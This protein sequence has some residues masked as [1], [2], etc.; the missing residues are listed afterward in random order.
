MKNLYT[1]VS[2]QRGSQLRDIARNA[3]TATNL[4]QKWK[5]IIVLIYEMY[6]AKLQ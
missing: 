5:Q 6:Q 4:G 3:G 2:F 1:P